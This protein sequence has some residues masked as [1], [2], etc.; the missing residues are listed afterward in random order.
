MSDVL[1]RGPESALYTRP[2][3]LHL[4]SVGRVVRNAARNL[5]TGASWARSVHRC[6]TFTPHVAITH[7]IPIAAQDGSKVSQFAQGLP[8]FEYDQ[9]K[10]YA[11]VRYT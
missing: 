7:T 4:V 3:A 11:E 9:E 1:P 2:D 8:G 5:T 6:V 10:P